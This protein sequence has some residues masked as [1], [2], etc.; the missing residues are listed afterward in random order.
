S[1]GK[2]YAVEVD[3]TMGDGNINFYRYLR[4]ET[5]SGKLK[6]DVFETTSWNN[7]IYDAL[8]V[9]TG[10]MTFKGDTTPTP[11]GFIGTIDGA[12]L[13][14]TYNTT[15]KQYQIVW[16]SWNDNRWKLQTNLFDLETVKHRGRFPSFVDRGF[17]STNLDLATAPDGGDVVSWT[18]EN[19]YNYE[20]ENII[21]YAVISDLGGIFVYQQATPWTLPIYNPQLTQMLFGNTMT[22]TGYGVQNWVSALSGIGHDYIT[23]SIL[24]IDVSFESEDVFATKFS[25]F[26]NGFMLYLGVWSGTMGNLDIGNT[27]TPQKGQV[28]VSLWYMVQDESVDTSINPGPCNAYSL[29]VCTY[30]NPFLQEDA[31][32]DY[33]ASIAPQTAQL[34]SLSSIELTGQMWGTFVSSTWMPKVAAGDFIAGVHNVYV[35]TNGKLTLLEASFGLGQNQQSGGFQLGQLPT[36]DS[37]Q[38]FAV[39]P[40]FSEF[41]FVVK[42]GYFDAINEAAKGRHWSNANPVDFDGDG[43]MDLVLGFATYST[44]YFGFDKI[45]MGVTYWENQGTRDEPIWV[46]RIH[47]VTNTDPDSG[48]RSQNFTDPLLVYD[49]YDMDQ[50][51]SSPYGF[52]PSFRTE[53]PQRLLMWQPVDHTNIFN[54]ELHTFYAEYDQPTSLLAATY[55]EA[56]RL[57]INLNYMNPG[58]LNQNINYGFHIFE[59]WDNSEELNDWTL[60]L[61]TA[62]LDQDEKNEIIVGD[63][64]NNIYVFE[65]LSNNTYKRAF[66]SFDI[67]RTI[68]TNQSPYAH[69]QFEGISG[70]FSRTLFDH[71]QYLIAG[72]D[73]NNNTLQEFIAATENMIFVFEATTT[74]T[75][76]IQDDTYQFIKI[77]DLL[78]L[79]TLVEQEPE[80]TVI[81]AMTWA[82]DMTQDG[83][84]ELIIAATSALLVFEVNK[85]FTPGYKQPGTFSVEEIF[86]GDSYD[87][88]GLYDLPGNYHVRPAFSVE[89]LLV[90]DLDTDG[91][92]DLAIGG[93]DRSGARPLWA[94][95]I[96]ILEWRGGGFRVM[97]AEGTFDETTEFNP[98][99]DFAVD[100]ADFDGL[101]ELLIAH[102]YGVDIYEF[103]GDNSLVLAEAD[104]AK[105]GHDKDVIRLQDETLLM[106][107]TGAGSVSDT[108]DDTLFFATSDDDG[109]TWRFDINMEWYV[110]DSFGSPFAGVEQPSLGQSPDG[111]IWLTFVYRTDVGG[112]DNLAVVLSVWSGAAWTGNIN[113]IISTVNNLEPSRMTPKLVPV[114]YANDQ[115]AWYI[116]Y[117]NSE[118]LRIW[119]TTNDATNGFNPVTYDWANST[120]GPEQYVFSSFDVIQL[121][122][123]QFYTSRNNYSLVF[124]GYLKA[125]EF[126]L[127]YDLFHAPI[128]FFQA[129]PP[130][131]Y[132]FTKPDR[133]YASG[134][135]ALSPSVIQERH[136]KNLLVTYEEATLRPY[137][138]LWAIWSNDGGINWNGPH[139]M[140]HPL[141]LDMPLLIEPIPTKS[142]ESYVISTTIGFDAVTEFDSHKP[143]VVPGSSKGFTMVYDVEVEFAIDIE[144]DPRKGSRIGLCSQRDGTALSNHKGFTPGGG[145]DRG[146][147]LGWIVSAI[148]PWSNFSWYNLGEANAIV[149]GDTDRDS[150]HEILVASGKQAFLYEFS[151]NAVGYIKHEEKWISKTYD[152]DITGIAISDAN[153]N[154]FPEIVLE[155]ERD[156][157][158]TFEV[159]DTLMGA[160]DL[161]Y[162]KQE[163][164]IP[165]PYTGTS[166]NSIMRIIATDVNNDDV[167]DILYLT[168]NGHMWALDGTD[169]SSIWDTVFPE[170]NPAFN[171]Y[172]LDLF[173]ILDFNVI[174]DVSSGNPSLLVV[175][176]FGNIT[177]VSA[178]SGTQGPALSYGT[179]ASD[180]IT[181]VHV[182]DIVPGGLEEIIVGYYNGSVY[183]LSST[184]LSELWSYD[185]STSV[186]NPD[187]A[188]II[189]IRSGMFSQNTTIEIVVV[190]R[191]GNLAVLDNLGVEQWMTDTKA[192]AVFVPA[193][194]V[195]ANSDGLQDIIFGD[196][197]TIA[198]NGFDGSQL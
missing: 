148:N 126:S 65:H 184:D 63:Y 103:T 71:V 87:L 114:P 196:N 118:W 179:G 138:G 77:I 90:E 120:Q 13:A 29:A 36:L 128:T 145:C 60:S 64:N 133:M 192:A 110:Q 124:S 86:Y 123:E 169:Y 17:Q 88:L 34:A 161:V 180:F 10:F 178:T 49:E 150:R 159:V 99:N 135:S 41:N 164:H 32:Q 35:V 107:F 47:A 72:F 50:V 14:V 146:I 42:G 158:Q 84:R 187:D 25:A 127:D 12:V 98:V 153:G 6:V 173:G 144:N 105:I 129:G 38:A 68:V 92:L 193:A 2:F 117:Q 27:P 76:R 131:L 108:F 22:T 172:L 176:N 28:D 190:N 191:E 61:S 181:S 39:T 130:H 79:P 183:A 9:E 166:D 142:R 188:D 57:D 163:A 97:E 15:T 37:L 162:S 43:D 58:G 140:S 154:G 170:P 23:M 106:V 31:F 40:S 18:A 16:D 197:I 174:H 70:E 121:D 100:D 21:E 83:R 69:E 168:R 26:E 80:D 4:F 119:E 122:E 185:F 198:I 44:P 109:E 52:H 152:R 96:N 82:D 11:V 186:V 5:F 85:A 81:T 8:S 59:T 20:N 54:G 45:T 160:S 94:G 194:I 95:F 93:T 175:N 55:P 147:D 182:A 7:P 156:I 67:N 48:F 171:M 165:T 66:K 116:Y 91:R 78:D 24:P 53:R 132:N 30:F 115:M 143:V 139:D 113:A 56:K 155:S 51:F 104:L 75:G 125:E 74:P 73:L 3:P 89:A 136:T 177:L 149:V 134:V 137:G 195:D 111:R 46:E 33:F 102:N 1:K 19:F 101:K 141:G 112:N 157:V 151:R 189:D 62:D 167:D